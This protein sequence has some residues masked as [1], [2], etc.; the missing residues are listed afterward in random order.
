MAARLLRTDAEIQAAGREHYAARP[1]EDWL[2]PERAA[3][4][5]DMLRPAYTPARRTA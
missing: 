3:W 4:L 2:T 1:R 5:A